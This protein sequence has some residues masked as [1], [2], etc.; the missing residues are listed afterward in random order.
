MF[1]IARD[2]LKWWNWC[3]QKDENKNQR[4]IGTAWKVFVFGVILES[5]VV[6]AVLRVLDSSFDHLICPLK[7]RFHVISSKL[8]NQN[9]LLKIC[10]NKDWIHKQKQ[11]TDIFMIDKNK[12]IVSQRVSCNNR[13]YWRYIVGYQVYRKTTVPL[14]IKTLK[15]IF[16]YGIS[17]CDKRF[18]FT[19]PF[20]DPEIQVETF[21]MRLSSS[22]MK[23]ENEVYKKSEGKHRLYN[24]FLL[25]W[26]LSMKYELYTRS[27]FK[28]TI[29]FAWA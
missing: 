12:E 22:N 20:N 14:F 1:P 13:K 5:E 2:L 6:N 7:N 9:V 25:N 17:Q 11:V 15:N 21:R 23:A 19:M 4:K 28:K 3:V 18:S 8:Y 24:F 27:F 26:K 29:F 16:T 10:F